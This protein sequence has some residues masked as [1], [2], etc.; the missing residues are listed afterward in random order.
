MKWKSP[1]TAPSL[2]ILAAITLACLLPFIDKA[3]H[4]DDPLFIWCARH[5]QSDPFD[6]YGFHLNWNGRMA[7]LAA[8][9][10]NPPLAAYYLS[11][12][13]SLFGWSEI[14]L[15]GGFLLPALAV[16]MGAFCLAR[17]FCSHPL[18]AALSQSLRRCFSSQAPVSCATR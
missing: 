2:F 14:A 4:I 13:G 5:L 8:V 15:H 10:Q 3:F 12:V 11:F 17:N 18:A 7:S 16:V 1:G 6:F 9:T